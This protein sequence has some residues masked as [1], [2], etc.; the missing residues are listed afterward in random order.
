MPCSIHLITIPEAFDL[1]VGRKLDCNRHTHITSKEACEL[2][3]SDVHGSCFEWAS[4]P[5]GR[6]SAKHL[7]IVAP[8][9][10]RKIRG[11]MQLVPINRGG[12]HFA[13]RRS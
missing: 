4:L 8:R 5:S 13:R 1:A 3:R 10:W 11:V 12:K 2:L 9:E 6:K 7:V